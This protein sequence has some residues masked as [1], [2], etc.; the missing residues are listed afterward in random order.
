MTDRNRWIVEGYKMLR[1]YLEL[2]NRRKK[3][4][5]IN[6]IMRSFIICNI[7]KILAYQ[8]DEGGWGVRGMC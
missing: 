8:R 7:H 5:E 1:K 2:G 3:G 4:L 6:F